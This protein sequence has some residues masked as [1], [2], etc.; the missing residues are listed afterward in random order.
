M[1]RR[2]KEEAAVTREKLIRAALR[3]FS[4]KGY[5]GTRLEEIAELAGLTRGAIYHHFGSKSELYMA[6]FE[7]WNLLDPV[8]EQAVAEGGNW[9][10][11]FRRVICRSLELVESNPDFQAML[12]LSFQKPEVPEADREWFVKGLEMKQ[13]EVN[14]ALDDVAAFFRLGMAED[15]LRDGIDPEV[16][17]QAYMGFFNGLASV[18]LIT[19]ERF[20]LKQNA[21]ALADIFIQ[22]I[23]K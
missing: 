1:M 15:H 9:L 21:A 20:S 3:A 18:W 22:G 2:T 8:I 13:A 17:A 5:G 14:K 6:V 23:M 19:K 12:E 11:K 7:T 10:E 16:A 4:E